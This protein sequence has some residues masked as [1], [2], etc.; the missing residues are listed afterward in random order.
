MRACRDVNLALAPGELL[1]LLGPSGC[2]KAPTPS[3]VSARGLA[4]VRE[5]T[6]PARALL[7]AY[8]RSVTS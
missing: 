3:R 6:F 2:G 7:R 1:V 5:R 4:G 8:R